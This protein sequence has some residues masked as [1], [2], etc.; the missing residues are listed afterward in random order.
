M[1]PA[2]VWVTSDIHI[3]YQDNFDRL[4][5]FADEGHYSDALIIAGD[6][7]DNMDKLEAL[8]RGLKPN[9]NL[10]CFVPGNHE[11]WLRRSAFQ[12]SLE[13]FFAI[14]KLCEAIGIATKPTLFGHREKVW[15]VPLYSWYDD[16]D[17]A[18]HSLFLEKDYAE[19]MTD[20]IWADFAQVRW[21]EHVQQPV[22]E[23]FATENEAHLNDKLDAP[24]ISFSHFL[25]RQ[26]LIFSSP[27]QM[28]MR[29]ARWF[30]PMPE[31]NF[32][33]VAGSRRIESQ[34]RQLGSQLHIYGHQHVNRV[35]E[36]DGI[37]YLSHCMGYPRERKRGRLR[38]S[39]ALPRCVWQDDVGFVDLHGRVGR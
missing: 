10:V 17:Q 33:R 9:F 24:I 31:F 27:R 2:K 38:E 7:T 28:S 22:A 12:H 39:A 21:P 18:E 35:R 30:D 5:A 32:T 3:D 13:K 11:L 25:P 16:K 29:A 34:V 6:A 14:R 26:E 8:F 23:W 19:D 1:M 15:L 37:T 20:A 4:L 36:I